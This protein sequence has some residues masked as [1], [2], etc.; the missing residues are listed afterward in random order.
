MRVHRPRTQPVAHVHRQ[1]PWIDEAAYDKLLYWIRE[2]YNIYLNRLRGEP[3]PWTE[4]KVLQTNFFTMPYREYDKTT[5]WVRDFIRDPNHDD[6]RVILALIIF[7]WFNYIPTGDIL[8]G[9]GPLPNLLLNW[10][11]D[12]AKRRLLGRDKI[13]TGAYNISNS[14]S[15]K[16]KLDRVIDDYINPMWNDRHALCHCLEVHEPVPTL[17]NAH[18]V[19]SSYLGMGGSGFMAYEVVCDLRFTYLLEDAP[20]VNSWCSMG[21]GASRGLHRLLGTCPAD[22]VGWKPTPPMGWKNHMQ[23]LLQRINGDLS[24]SDKNAYEITDPLRCKQLPR[25][26]MR[27]VEHTLCEFDKY[28]RACSGIKTKRTY[29]GRF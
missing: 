17:Q 20:D 24:T 25:F 23:S 27:E 26:E 29:P 7:R 13:F 15:T 28:M 19:L 10:D 1:D 2:R 9:T 5:R 8:I 12:E 14:G 4:D 11:P 18:K 16:S 22:T 6:P 3:K 21:P